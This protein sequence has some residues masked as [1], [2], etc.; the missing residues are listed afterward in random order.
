M[1]IIEN[2]G[3]TNVEL[4]F[5]PNNENYL[6]L[7]VSADWQASIIDKNLTGVINITSE[8]IDGSFSVILTIHIKNYDEQM[9][10]TLDIRDIG[11]Q[12][13]VKAITEK[14]II[15]VFAALPNEAGRA[16]L[17]GQY[18]RVFY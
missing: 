18:H 13:I 12:E 8:R 5:K 10:L 1:R 11:T 17:Y 2:H 3:I 14:S 6:A 4:E 7:I 9:Y 16:Q 15:Y